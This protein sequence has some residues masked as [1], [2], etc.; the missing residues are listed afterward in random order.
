MKV[1]Q[2]LKGFCYY[3]ATRLY[4]NAAEAAKHYSPDT[5]WVDAP[6]YV[7]EGWG[8]DET[9]EGDARFIQPL[10][11]EGWEYDPENGTYYQEGELPPSKPLTADVMNAAAVIAFV[12][13]AEGGKIDDVT[14][15]EY[16]ELFSPWA[17]GVQYEAG[18]LRQYGGQLYR[19]VQAHRSQAD[20]TPDVTANFW[21]KAADPGEEWP[22]WSQ[23]VGAHDT[24]NGGDKVSHNG[25]HWTSDVN[26]NV[27]EPGVYGWTPIE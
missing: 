14:A 20:W 2:I 3:D 19:C 10:P 24:Y 12:T 16:T 26:N 18:N 27:W 13:L 15:G 8:Y 23:P 7:F 22:E 21:S 5:V 25:K 11:P 4:P 17:S 9:K 6:D 1:F